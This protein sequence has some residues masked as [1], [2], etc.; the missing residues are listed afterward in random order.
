MEEERGTKGE[1]V[2]RQLLDNVL[3]YGDNNA[4]FCVYSVLYC[5]SSQKNLF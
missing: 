5:P 4:M 3:L 1:R 2:N